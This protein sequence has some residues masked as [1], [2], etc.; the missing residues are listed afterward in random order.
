MDHAGLAVE[1]I[2]RIEHLEEEEAPG[3]LTKALPR[4]IL[5]QVVKVDEVAAKV[6]CCQIYIRALGVQHALDVHGSRE[7]VTLHLYDILMV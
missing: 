6:L 1:V 3:V 2:E 5:D 7:A 4:R